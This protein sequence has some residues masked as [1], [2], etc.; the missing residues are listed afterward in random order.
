[1]TQPRCVV[2]THLV[3]DVLNASLTRAHIPAAVDGDSNDTRGTRCNRNRKQV[4]VQS[5]MN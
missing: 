5:R 1:M 3:V 4:G 2:Q